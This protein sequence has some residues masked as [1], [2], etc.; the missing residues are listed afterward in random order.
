ML[1]ALHPCSCGST[2]VL[3][4]EVGQWRIR[5]GNCPAS[6]IGESE[7]AARER[8]DTGSIILYERIITRLTF[9]NC[10]IK[11]C[12]KDPHNLAYLSRRF[13]LITYIC[14][15]CGRKHR[16]LLCEPGKLGMPR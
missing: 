3:L 12:C 5:C 4:E 10:P 2:P 11:D 16:R 7:A 6:V 13:D 1:A 9:T 14:R 15:I 8:W